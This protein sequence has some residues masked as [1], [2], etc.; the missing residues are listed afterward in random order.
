[1]ESQQR[2]KSSEVYLFPVMTV[3]SKNYVLLTNA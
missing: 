3:H 2:T 1:M